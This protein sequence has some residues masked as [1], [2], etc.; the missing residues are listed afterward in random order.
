MAERR[1]PATAVSAPSQLT[2]VVGVSMVTRIPH[3]PARFRAFAIAAC[4]LTGSA[5]PAFAAGPKARLSADLA[6]HLTNGSQEI[7]VIV[8]GSK[9]EVDA[10]AIRYNVRIVRF[11]AS[12]A[13]LLVNAGQLAALRDDGSIDHLSGDLRIKSSV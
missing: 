5:V 8:H 4:L 6:D 10:I 11:M 9:A 1:P 12:G 7:R 2:L 3:A 13:V